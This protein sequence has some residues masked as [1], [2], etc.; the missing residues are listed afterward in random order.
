M[1]HLA[2]EVGAGAA[3]VEGLHRAGGALV[4]LQAAVRRGQRAENLPQHLS[5]Y[6][7]GNKNLA[8]SFYIL[9]PK[10]VTVSTCVALML[11][12]RVKGA[13]LI[14]RFTVTQASRAPL[15]LVIIIIIIIIFIII[16]TWC[17]CAG[18]CSPRR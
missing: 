9:L 16:I 12:L 1:P 13:P 4:P 10:N 6:Y 3:V 5:R 2:G 8:S 11:T 14:K 18:Q 15:R 7:S 17:R